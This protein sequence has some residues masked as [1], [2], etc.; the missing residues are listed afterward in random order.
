MDR[1]TSI[2]Q[3]KPYCV[4]V[5]FFAS[6]FSAEKPK[7]LRRPFIS[8]IVGT[9]FFV[10]SNGYVATANHVAEAVKDLTAETMFA[11]QR[12]GMIGLALPNTDWSR[13]NFVTLPYEIVYVD[14]EQ[15]LA[16]LKPAANPFE[17]NVAPRI[18]IG[19][20]EVKL[21]VASAPLN[22][23]RPEDGVELAISG[24][25]LSEPVLVTSGGWLASAWAMSS[26]EPPSH[27]VYLADVDVNPGN[28]G[29]PV[30]LVQDAS[31][32]GV[33]VAHKTAPVRGSEEGREQLFY[34]SG[35]TVVVP[36]S[37][38]CELLARN[39]VAWTTA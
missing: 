7:E 6:Q 11:E 25:P 17:E 27:D 30:Y 19:G 32:I 20:N 16:L 18:S 2:A 13:A 38:L 10:N 24:Y 14:E 39:D 15:D 8:Q 3:A 22:S 29:G 28:S 21:E 35:L 9:G 34:G 31:V 26:V 4:Q 33:C 37:A 5:S 23:E 1:P 12:G 36:T